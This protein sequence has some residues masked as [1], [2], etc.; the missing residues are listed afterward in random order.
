[1]T[2]TSPFIVFALPRSRTS[3]LSHFLSIGDFKCYHE[4]CMYMRSVDDLK[5]WLA[6]DNTG[7]AETG[8]APGWRLIKHFRPDIRTLVVRRPVDEV[9][10]SLLKIDLTGVGA[11]EETKLRKGMLYLDR[12]L[13]QIEQQPGTLSVKFADLANEETCAR[14]FE[15][16]LPYKHH[17][18]WWAEMAAL[19]LQIN[20]RAL[21][22][23][24]FTHRAQIDAFKAECWSTLRGLRE[25]GQIAGRGRQPDEIVTQIESFAAFWRDGQA[26][27]AEH[28]AEVGGRDGVMLDPNIEL[29]ERIERGGGAQILTAR[30]GGKMIGYLVF[31]IAPSLEDK[32]AVC[33]MQNT[34]FV[35]KQHRGLGLRLMR[36]AVAHLKEKGVTEAI[37]RAGVRGSGPKLVT[38]FKRMGAAEYGRLYNLMLGA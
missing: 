32:S 34:F 29:A 37:L 21:L 16:C 11:Y 24:R 26:L 10:A 23:Y 19:N 28:A 17:H 12:C 35:S 9:V 31:L 15:H 27:F 5:A 18:D 2:D 20:T 14:V 1:M 4:Q 25:A 13:D 30:L 8:A 36:E 7:A 6:Q 22:R 38:L 3:W 33:A